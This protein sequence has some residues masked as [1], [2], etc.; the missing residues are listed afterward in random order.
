VARPRPPYLNYL[1]VPVPRQETPHR[2]R[3]A[4]FLA[5]VGVVT[6]VRSLASFIRR[7][8]AGV[9]RDQR[10]TAPSNSNRGV[11]VS[12]EA[13]RGIEALQQM[14]LTETMYRR[15]LEG[16]DEDDHPLAQ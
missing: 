7:R 4:C 14:L 13:M 15:L 8:S 11:D 5:S 10:T 6:V 12:A 16:D 1:S 2:I 3:R 9:R